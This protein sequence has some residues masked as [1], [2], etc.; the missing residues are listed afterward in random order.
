MNSENNGM[1][2]RVLDSIFS[3]EGAKRVEVSIS[4]VE[5]YNDQAFD[6]LGPN[7]HLPFSKK[8][9]VQTD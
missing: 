9:T 3:Y 2:P 7:P 6:L 1:A 8:G 5:V 4:F